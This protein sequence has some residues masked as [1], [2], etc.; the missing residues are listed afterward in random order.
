MIAVDLLRVP[1]PAVTGVVRD[2]SLGA[3]PVQRGAPGWPAVPAGPIGAVLVIIPDN[4]VSGDLQLTLNGIGA[5]RI[6]LARSVPAVRDLLPRLGAGAMAVVSSAF[7]PETDEMIRLLRDNGWQ[8]V[9]VLTPSGATGPAIAA[10]AAGATGVLATA[11]AGPDT[12]TLPALRPDLSEREIQILSLVADG[13]SNKQIGARLTVSPLTV[14]SHLA[15]IGRK[16]G[17]G[18]RAHMVAIAHRSGILT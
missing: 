8:R 11:E 9:L 2:R 18:D 6:L 17:V 1:G 3:L 15:R 7:G 16:L 13:C 10:F 14:K 4:A 12:T 5:Y